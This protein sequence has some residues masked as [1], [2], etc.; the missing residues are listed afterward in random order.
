MQLNDVATQI[1]DVNS[2]GKILCTKTLS[3]VENG[4]PLNRLEPIELSKELD[5]QL[6]FVEI[7]DQVKVLLISGNSTESI[8]KQNLKTEPLISTD[9]S[10]DIDYFIET[11][12]VQDN[13][14]K[15][16]EILTDDI[17]ASNEKLPA[18]TVIESSFP[19]HQLDTNSSMKSTSINLLTTE[20]ALSTDVVEKELSTSIVHKADE[21]LEISSSKIVDYIDISLFQACSDD[22]KP[23]AIIITS[24]EFSLINVSEYRPTSNVGIESVQPVQGKLVEKFKIHFT[25]VYILS[26]CD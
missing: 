20:S 3:T 26:Y 19:P 24:E 12:H 4:A 7:N 22:Q 17:Q 14:F 6:E 13:L 15:T 2:P 1:V 11:T 23:E 5:N 16:K 8:M 10:N 18:T 25:L 9:L 21:L